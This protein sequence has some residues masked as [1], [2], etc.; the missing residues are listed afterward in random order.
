MANEKCLGNRRDYLTSSAQGVL[1]EGLE[2]LC[3]NQVVKVGEVAYNRT[4][5]HVQPKS[6][7]NKRLQPH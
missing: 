1:G 6:P 2:T 7:L 4:K 5:Y 3:F